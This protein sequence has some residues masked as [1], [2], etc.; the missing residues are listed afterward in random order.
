MS[1]VVTEALTRSYPGKRSDATPFVALNHVDLR[2][3]EGEVHGLLGPNGAGKTTLCRILSTVLCPTSGTARVFGHDVD[4]APNEV[5]RIVGVVFG[6]ER[7]LYGRLSSRQNLRFWAALYGLHGSALRARVDELLERTGLADRANDRV[8]TMSRG[9]KQRLHIA[10]GL[11]ADPPLL[12]FDE[13]TAGLDPIS[14]RDFRAL[15]TDLRGNGHTII[16]ATHDMTE[17][18]A[19]CDRVTFIDHGRVIA[20]ENT[21]GIRNLVARVDAVEARQVPP[22]TVVG[23]RGV[24]GVRAVEQAADDS[25]RVLTDSEATTRAVLTFLLEAGVSQLNTPGPTLADVYLSLIEDR[26]MAVR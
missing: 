12:I 15:V 6:G 18:E 7:G 26:G 17:A 20:T 3:E 23:L 11:V 14:A 4:I 25:I 9:M 21:I 16:L 1:A 5:R 2:I 8:D 10:R 13:P 19:L 22:D 24:P